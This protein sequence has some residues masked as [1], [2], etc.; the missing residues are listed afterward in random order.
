MTLRLNSAA[1]IENLR[2]YPSEIVEKLK[3][4]LTRGAIA[5]A[6]IHREN[7]Y[8]VV[9]GPRVYFIH[10]SPLTNKVMLLATW[11]TESKLE[12]KPALAGCAA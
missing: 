4:A 3:K 7:F 11:L 6:D 10:V 1:T 8:D 2:N 12:K 9:D 5:Y